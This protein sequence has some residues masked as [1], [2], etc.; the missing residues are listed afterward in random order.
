MEEPEVIEPRQP[1][2]EPEPGQN[3]DQPV[4]NEDEMMFTT[5]TADDN[6]NAL[7]EPATENAE[8][9]T[10][11]QSRVQEMVMQDSAPPVLE[12]QTSTSLPMIIGVVGAVCIVVGLTLLILQKIRN[13]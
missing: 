13:S 3:P 2:T 11:Q 10:T 1:V 12:P 9:F 4:S 5:Q 7:P 8:T 6:G